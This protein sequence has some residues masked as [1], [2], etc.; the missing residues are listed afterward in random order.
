MRTA[1]SITKQEPAAKAPRQYPT[2]WTWYAEDQPE[3]NETEQS[4]RK[5]LRLIEDEALRIKGIIIDAVK[6]PK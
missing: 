2:E 3:K 1:S 5:T 6:D 4:P